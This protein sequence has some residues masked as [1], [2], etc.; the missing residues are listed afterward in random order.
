[1]VNRCSVAYGGM[2]LYIVLVYFFVW[3]CFVCHFLPSPRV[4]AIHGNEPNKRRVF[5]SPTILYLRTEQLAHL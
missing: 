1:M 4:T 3:V 2:R 5:F